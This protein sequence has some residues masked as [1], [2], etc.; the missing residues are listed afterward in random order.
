MPSS[1]Y[2]EGWE[3]LF[4]HATAP[5]LA[6]FLYGSA[7][8][9]GSGLFACLLSLPPLARLGKYSFEAVL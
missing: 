5:L 6:L 8:Q 4:N 2:H 7:A 3:P 1:G 9:Q